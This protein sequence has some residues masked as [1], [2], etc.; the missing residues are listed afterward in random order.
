MQHNRF[1]WAADRTP[2]TPALDTRQWLQQGTGLSA[3]WTDGDVRSLLQTD[4]G[5]RFQGLDQE[6]PVR[7]ALLTMFILFGLGHKDADL[8]FLRLGYAIRDPRELLATAERIRSEP[9]FR[10]VADGPIASLAELHGW[11]TTV[12]MA[13]FAS[14]GRAGVILGGWLTWLK[15]IDRPLFYA[16]HSVALRGGAFAEG[17]AAYCQYGQEVQAG[18]ALPEYH[19]EPAVAG[20]QGSLLHLEA[21]PA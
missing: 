2:S 19:L 4:L 9:A 20:V 10:A 7:A 14:A 5:I 12:V 6:S 13:A 11:S 15:D 3:G 18:R 16:L 21:T 8:V 1:P 17:A